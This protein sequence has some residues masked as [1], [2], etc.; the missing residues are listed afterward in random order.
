SAADGGMGEREPDA[1]P[2]RIGEKQQQKRRRRQH[3]PKAE[4]VAV[5]LE[6]IP[7]ADIADGPAGDRVLESEIGH[8]GSGIRLSGIGVSVSGV[9]SGGRHRLSRRLTPWSRLS[10]TL[11]PLIPAHSASKTRVN[12]LMLGIQSIVLETLD[13]R[14]RGDERLTAFSF[15]QTRT[16]DRALAP[17]A[18]RS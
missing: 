11:P 18:R 14:F 15:T 6:P 10:R 16:N 9:R 2:E 1:E 17:G 4:P 8:Q 7:R 13:P 12:A 3:E 5:H